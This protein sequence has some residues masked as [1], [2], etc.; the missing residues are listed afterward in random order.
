MEGAL[1]ASLKKLKLDYV[2]LYLLHWM[3]PKTDWDIEGIPFKNTPTHKV[4]AEL[5]RLVDLGLI[6]SIGVSN[7]TVPM[8][9]DLLS[10]AKHR[11]VTNQVE[12]HPYL[13]QRD[14]VAFHKKL[15]V[16]VTAYAPLGANAWSLKDDK[17][18]NLNLLEEPVVKELSTKYGKTP[19]QIILNWHTKCRGHIVIP[20]TINV[21]RLGENFNVF[22]FD[23]SE[24]D[25]EK[26]NALDQK[27]RFFNPIAYKEYGWNYCPY[28]E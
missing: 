14:F 25:Y 6:K 10:Y 18:K 7:C 20:K 12:L 23:M 24:E 1:R 2:D 21:G 22:D 26:V 27:A 19:A 15:G 4:W 9:M 16:T 13:S 28:F 3:A 11:P 8:L 5:E 17:Y